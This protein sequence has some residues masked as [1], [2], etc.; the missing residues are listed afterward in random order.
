[1]RSHEQQ[2]NVEVS[3]AHDRSS[4][5]MRLRMPNLSPSILAL[6]TNLG[7]S[8]SNHGGCS[9]KSNTDAL[10]PMCLL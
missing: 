3:V 5:P 10:R 7:L 2:N 9:L 4:S 6:V 8:L 1:M